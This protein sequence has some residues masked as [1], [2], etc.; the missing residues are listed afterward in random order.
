MYASVVTV[1]LL[2]DCGVSGSRYG[3]ALRVAVSVH[4]PRLLHQTPEAARD[5]APVVVADE[6]EEEKPDE[7]I[8]SGAPGEPESTA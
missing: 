3:P 8:D 7:T 4:R 6:V 5:A 1:F 2:S